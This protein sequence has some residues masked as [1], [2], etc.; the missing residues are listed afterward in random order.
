[1][2]G[3]SNKDLPPLTEDN[4]RK[5]I[6]TLSQRKSSGVPLTLHPTFYVCP[7]CSLLGRPCCEEHRQA[8]RGT[9]L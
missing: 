6:E 1:M 4:I 2:N 5:A 3:Y 8:T 9:P 7:A